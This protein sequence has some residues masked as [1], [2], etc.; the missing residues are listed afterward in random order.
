MNKENKKVEGILG[1]GKIDKTN[2]DAIGIV[3]KPLVEASLMNMIKD[4]GIFPVEDVDRSPR[5]LCNHNNEDLLKEIGGI[6]E[7]ECNTSTISKTKIDDNDELVFNPD[8]FKLTKEQQE[9]MDKL[10]EWDEKRN[11]YN[12]SYSHDNIFSDKENETSIKYTNRPLFI[13]KHLYDCDCMD[14]D[15]FHMLP[16]E[17][18]IFANKLMTVIK[19]KVSFVYTIDNKQI[20]NLFMKNEFYLYYKFYNF[21]LNSFGNTV[22]VEE[23][24]KNDNLSVKVVITLTSKKIECN[25]L[26]IENESIN[27]T[28]RLTILDFEFITLEELNEILINDEI[29]M[30]NEFLYNSKQQDKKHD[31]SFK[32][33][34]NKKF[35]VTLKELENDK[36]SVQN[37]SVHGVNENLSNKQHINEKYLINGGCKMSNKEFEGAYVASPLEEKEYR[38]SK[39]GQ[40]DIDEFCYNRKGVLVSVPNFMQKHSKWYYFIDSDSEFSFR[41]LISKRNEICD[42]IDFIDKSIDKDSFNLIINT[43]NRTIKNAIASTSIFSYD[44]YN[45]F[46]SLYQLAVATTINIFKTDRNYKD[47]IKITNIKSLIDLITNDDK[48]KDIIM[49]DINNFSDDLLSREEEKQL[50]DDFISFIGM[51]LFDYVLSRTDMI[52]KTNPK[53]QKKIDNFGQLL[54]LFAYDINEVICKDEFKIIPNRLSTVNNILNALKTLKENT[55]QSKVQRYLDGINMSAHSN[56]VTDRAERTYFIVGRYNNATSKNVLAATLNHPGHDLFDNS[57]IIDRVH[58]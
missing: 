53:I 38:G 45:I 11:P 37:I 17:H 39:P 26:A 1:T 8:S 31:F 44:S 13:V 32:T 34:D 25:C 41:S 33:K 10:R 9:V 5:Y 15:K 23:L 22:M 48:Y 54:K 19:K 30:K 36:L 50:I 57:W 56:Y 14:L 3:R 2:K 6:M 58:D 16:D 20:I 29:K 7:N 27:T 40:M 4:F 51:A 28:S 49:Y 35:N 55:L 46:A 43:N 42:R 12:F 18:D 52:D 21:I 24:L 47:L